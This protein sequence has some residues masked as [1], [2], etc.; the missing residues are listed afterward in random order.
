[1]EKT[2]DGFVSKIIAI[3]GKI[4]SNKIISSIQE[5][6]IV[7]NPFIILAS[8]ATLFTSLICSPKA[9]LATVHGFE[10][11]VGWNSMWS[12]IYYGCLNLIALLLAFNMAHSL[13]KRYDVDP[14][15]GGF[16]G[17]ISYVCMSPTSFPVMGADGVI[18]TGL[19]QDVTGSMGMF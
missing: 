18:A 14:L 17:L 6:F 5:A 8:I 10:F 3:S 12:G 15:F 9:G 7:L 11:L 2:N 13:A 4:N 19:S 16:L 1:M